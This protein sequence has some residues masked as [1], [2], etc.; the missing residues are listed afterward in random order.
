MKIFF[1][2]P[3]TGMLVEDE[4]RLALVG[5]YRDFLSQ[6]IIQLE[7][8]GHFVISSHRREKWGTDI[9]EP[10]RAIILDFEGLR[11]CDLVLALIGDPPSADVQMELGYALSFNKDMIVIH[12][13]PFDKLP[14]LTKG[15]TAFKNVYMIEAISYENILAM[16]S[17]YPLLSAAAR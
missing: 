2:A 5:A 17:T 4:G 12:S 6:V 1:A 14:H 7:K 16:L 10:S 8:I 3:F 9:H 15:L 13:Q 11:S